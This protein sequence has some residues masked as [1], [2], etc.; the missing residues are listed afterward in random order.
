MRKRIVWVTGDYFI[1][2]DMPI[3]PHLC[4]EYDIEWIIIRGQDEKIEVPTSC[5]GCDI[6]T[7]QMSFRRRDIRCISFYAR[8]ARRIKAFNPD[9]IYI[10]AVEMPY[11][12]P[13]FD[14]YL[15]RH[16]MVHAAH[17]VVSYPGW[18]HRR[19]N[20]M[21]IKY[22][23]GNHKNFHIFSQHTRAVFEQLYSG[24]NILCT[25]LSLKDYGTPSPSASLDDEKVKF[26]FFGNFRHNKRPDVL[27][28]AFARLPIELRN[29]AHLSVMGSCDNTEPYMPLVK[30]LGDS[31]TFVP[32]RIPDEDVADIFA[33]HHYLVLPYEN[34]AQS[35]PH[36]IAYN[37]NV[38]VIATR[39]DGFVEHVTDGYDGYLFDVNN[40]DS[41]A[42]VLK[43]VIGNS[44]EEYNVLCDNLKHTIAQ[45]YSSAA[46]LDNYKR[47]FDAL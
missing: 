2:V 20:E 7:Y 11:L 26:L 13:V 27:L 32:T 23:F 17:N 19:M 5:D 3:V 28:Q 15:P 40:V 14:F 29:K 6:H 36:M 33:S 45:K 43:R 21:Y 18:P 1:D 34:V 10:D 35:G 12:Y 4:R 47:Y 37:Y 30:E 22:I 25:P 24:K 31:V 46:I 42:E 9:I 44:K 41:L 8:I 38:P 39:I 16:K